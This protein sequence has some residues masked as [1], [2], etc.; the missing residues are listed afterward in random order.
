LNEPVRPRSIIVSIGS[1]IHPHKNIV[2]VISILKRDFNLIRVSSVVETEP[3]RSSGDNFLNL[4][5]ELIT[6]LPLA[7][8]KIHLRKIEAEM[9]RVRTEDKYAPR[10]MDLD[11]IMDGDLLLD[12]DLWERVFVAVPVAELR[13]MLRHPQSGLPIQQLARELKEKSWIQVHPAPS[14]E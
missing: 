10:P 1:N 5:V 9:G 11:V 13:P 6:T 7:D 3:Y 4:A 8:I 2:R 12:D 14:L